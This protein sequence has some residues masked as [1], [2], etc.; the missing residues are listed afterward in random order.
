[1]A[2]EGMLIFLTTQ[3]LVMS[4]PA[5]LLQIPVSLELRHRGHPTQ[6]ITGPT[7]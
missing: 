5:C 1:M 7:G 4:L 3:A 6:N 2:W